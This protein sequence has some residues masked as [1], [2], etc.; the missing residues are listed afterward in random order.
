MPFD[1]AALDAID[2][3]I[4]SVFDRA[5]ILTPD[6]VRGDSE[7]LPD[8]IRSRGWPTLES[9]RGK[10]MF[11][12]DSEG[13]LRDLYLD[14]HPALRGRLLFASVRP[15]GPAAAWMKRP[16]PSATSTTSRPSSATASS[17]GPAPERRHEAN[18][19][20]TTHLPARQGWPA[21]LQFVV[22][23]DLPR[24]PARVL[25]LLSA[26]MPRG[27]VARADP[28]NGPSSEADLEGLPGPSDR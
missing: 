22:S 11:A 12:L 3:E 4:L 8:A 1:R 2:A 21:A 27:G 6:N 16:I 5:H 26:K 15:H 28:V 20:R 18:R 10:V 24:A 14:G 25:D 19:G 17:S 7:T 23:T 9:C 13:K